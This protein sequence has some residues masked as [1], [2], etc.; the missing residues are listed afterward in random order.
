MSVMSNVQPTTVQLKHLKLLGRTSTRLVIGI[1]PLSTR[2]LVIR[3]AVGIALVWSGLAWWGNSGLMSLLLIGAGI[4]V[5]LPAD[6]GETLIF[7]RQKDQFRRIQHRFFWPVERVRHPL[8]DVVE[9]TLAR[10]AVE[11]Y[12]EG[13]TV[14]RCQ[15]ILKLHSQATLLIGDYG[16]KSGMAKTSGDP[17][18]V[19]ETMIR[20]I[21]A[22][23]QAGT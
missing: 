18:Q 20:W 4:G 11:R 12:A 1:R 15:V 10:E 21:R 17:R 9:A 19:A 14:Y 23:L 6:L 5:A 7:D 2:I 22:F 3:S 16:V 13:V 8:S